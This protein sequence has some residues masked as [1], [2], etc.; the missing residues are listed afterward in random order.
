MTT[1]NPQ[2]KRTI[3]WAASALA[4]VLSGPAPAQDT[5]QEEEESLSDIIVTGSIRQGGAQDIKH[6]RSVSLDGSFLPE[7]TSLTVEGLLGEHDLTMPQLA[8]CRQTFCI[9]GHAM[10]ANLPVRPDDQ[11]LIGLGFASN[12]DADSWRGAP[13]SLVA[14]VD[15]SGSM[16]GV[17]GR[18]RAALH[19]AV[20]QLRDGDRFG[21]V[22]YGSEP[23]V[24]LEVTEIKG[25]RDALHRAID[26][27]QIEGSTAMEA[28]LAKGYEVAE[29]ELARSRGKTRMMLFTD[30]NPN[31]GNTH[32]TGFMAQARAGSH[33]GIGLTTIGVGVHFDAALATKVSS[34]RGGNLFFL[35]TDD[36]ARTLFKRD[37]FNLVS[38]VANDLEFALTPPPGYKITGVFGV[39]DEIMSQAPEGTVTVKI[40]TAFL[41]SNG[42]GIFVALGK[43]TGRQFL[44]A[45]GLG[46]DVPLL[47][48]TL[49]W[50]DARTGAG[51]A[52]VLKV[53]QPAGEAPAALRLGHALIDEYVTLNAALTGYYKKN[54]KK[55][56][57]HLLDG[58]AQRLA[59]PDLKGIEAERTLVAGLRQRAALV[60]G[61]AGE[62]PRELRPLQVKGQ[63][64]VQS[65]SGLDDLGRGDRV[66]I[67]SDGEFVTYRKRG[68]EIRQDIE[69][70][71]NQLYIREANLVFNYRVSGDRLTLVT[72]DGLSEVRM[73]R[74][75]G[76]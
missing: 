32:A 29:A 55:G 74:L 44:P 9:S 68:D 58:L 51:G 76:N 41:S 10:R 37:F 8:P 26:A 39:P 62:V 43:D 23:Q 66:E 33:K 16:T 65:Y 36:A 54:D 71:E 60:A 50:S 27:I 64:R 20:D 70:N 18:V 11:W 56:A 63:W 40:G 15:R 22:H 5:T 34:V 4:L 69:V 31:V 48:G 2:P 38:E 67:N 53:A 75:T 17:I 72:P 14:V 21:I 46:S 57:Y 13:L 19:Q 7:T 1:F 28:G 45:A 42:G 52:D 47:T 24:H 49:R 73:Q 6:F 59:D 3:A 61:Y 35:D 25:N 12:I 30:E